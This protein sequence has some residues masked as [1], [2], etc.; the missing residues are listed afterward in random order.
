MEQPAAGRYKLQKDNSKV[1][2]RQT[3]SFILGRN[4]QQNDQLEVVMDMVGRPR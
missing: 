1:G 3:W 4:K 2:G